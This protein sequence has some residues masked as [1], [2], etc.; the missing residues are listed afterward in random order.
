MR[1]F[2]VC[3]RESCSQNPR[4]PSPLG[5][6]KTPPGGALLSARRFKWLCALSVLGFLAP[7]AQAATLVQ[8]F[9]LPMPEPQVYQALSTIQSGISTA[10]F[11]IYSVVV[12]GSGTQIYY[13]QWED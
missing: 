11:S 2:K 4:R 10:Q 1:P 13:D 8:E 9:Y 12:T 5:C 7:L 6:R 3:W